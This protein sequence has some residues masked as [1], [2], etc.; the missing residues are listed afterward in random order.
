MLRY[1]NFKM[2][3]NIESETAPASRV[4]PD[5]Q[6]ERDN[7]LRDMQFALHHLSRPNGLPKAVRILKSALSALK[8]QL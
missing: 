3:L 4:R 2:K 1:P 6:T 7:L 5:L 8:G